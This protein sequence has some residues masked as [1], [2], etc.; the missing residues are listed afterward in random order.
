MISLYHE[1][2][3]ILK[4]FYIAYLYC[5]YQVINHI[6]ISQIIGKKTVSIYIQ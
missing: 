5:I 1:I 3:Y 2:Y 4:L 6:K